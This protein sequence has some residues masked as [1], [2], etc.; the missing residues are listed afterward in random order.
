MKIALCVNNDHRLINFNEGTTLQIY[1][2]SEEKW[3]LEDT[4]SYVMDNINNMADMRGEIE[5][6]VNLIGECKTLVAKK[7]SGLCFTVFETSGFEIWEMDATVEEVL[8]SFTLDHDEDKP[9]EIEKI[10]YFKD[11]GLGVYEINLIEAM[12]VDKNATSK[13]LLLPFLR[14][15]GFF[16]VDVI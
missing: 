3:R 16:K 11:K 8:A 7:I 14:D 10:E 15:G 5:R 1:F 2:R 6:I 4:I 12:S 9:E 13:S